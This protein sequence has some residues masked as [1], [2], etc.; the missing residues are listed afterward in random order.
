M[1]KIDGIDGLTIYVENDYSYSS[2]S[3]LNTIR[4]SMNV[5][6]RKHL[7]IPAGAT[8][9]FFSD[10]SEYRMK[11]L[12][13]DRGSCANAQSNFNRIFL[14]LNMDYE[15][16]KKY[17]SKYEA[18]YMYPYLYNRPDKTIVHEL[19][20]LYERKKLAI[21]KNFFSPSWKIEGY[22]DYIAENSGIVAAYALDCFLNSKVES[23]TCYS[24]Y[25]IG[26]LR[27]DYLLRHKGVP[28]D[29]YWDTKYDTDKLD[30][31]IRA[32]LRS[33]EYRMFEK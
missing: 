27:T 9:Y 20:H 5:L 2:D 24:I 4:R 1:K 3:L 6:E 14:N 12:W 11:S 29:E 15:I 18:E 19:T 32:A 30:D 31:E 25:F 17:I 21:M 33:G 10:E 28:E 22:A 16:M 8:L 23:S 26:H 13:L 7:H